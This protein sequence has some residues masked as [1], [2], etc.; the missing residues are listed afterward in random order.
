MGRTLRDQDLIWVVPCTGGIDFPIDTPAMPMVVTILEQEY[1]VQVQYHKFLNITYV[2]LDA[3]IFRQQTKSDPYPARMDDLDSAIYYSAWNQC[4][5]EVMR[6]FHVDLYHINDYH[7][8]V[9]PLYLL[10]ERT[11]P[12]CLSLHNAEFQGLWPCRTLKERQEIGEVF[13]LPQSVVQKYVQFGEVFNLLHAGASILR[14][15]QNGFGAVGVSTKYGKRSYIR[16]PIFWGLKRVGAL[17]NPDPTDMEDWDKSFNNSKLTVVDQEFEAR[18]PSQKRQAQEW[19]GL[20]QRADAD[21][22]VFVGRWSMQKGIDLIADVFP[23]VLERYA[24]VQLLCI[25]PVIDLYGK[26]AALKLQKMMVKYPGRVFSKPEFTALPPFVFTG[27]EFA[28]IPSRDEPFGLVAVEFGR[29][30]ALGVGARVGG[31]GQ[32]PGWWY[33]IESMTTKHLVYQ[34][35]DAIHQALKS[36][37]D[38]R[39]TMRARSAKTRFPVQQWKADLEIL[40]SGSI[41]AHNKRLQSK[42]MTST[43]WKSS[44]RSASKSQLE[45]GGQP[46]TSSLGG[47]STPSV[48]RSPQSSVTATREST[49]SQDTDEYDMGTR[50]SP[51]RYFR[52]CYLHSAL[53]SCDTSQNTSP[54]G[55]IERQSS[56][57]TFRSTPQ[58]GRISASYKQNRSIRVATSRTSSAEVIRSDHERMSF[59]SADQRFLRPVRNTIAVRNSL[60]T[61]PNP[62]VPLESQPE[63]SSSRVASAPA[64]MCSPVDIA[65]YKSTVTIPSS[66][67][68]KQP[69]PNL[70]DP[71]RSTRSSLS[72]ESN[73]E[74]GTTSPRREF[75][76]FNQRRLFGLVHCSNR[77][78]SVFSGSTRLE[79]TR[80]QQHERNLSLEEV[81][82]CKKVKEQQDLVPFFTDPTGQYYR[83]F[84]SKLEKLSAKTS[85]GSL[86]V[87]E[88]L[89]ES[90]RDWFNRLHKAR[91]TPASS[92]TTTPAESVRDS[93]QDSDLADDN[94]D[95]FLLPDAYEPPKG[96][97]RLL[98]S[99]IHRHGWP[100][101]TLLLALGQILSANSYQVTLL[102]GQIGQPASKLYI[103]ACIYLVSSL[104]CWIAFRW[105]KALYILCLPWLFY[106]LAF[107]F[108]G[109]SP[110]GQTVS[111]RGWIQDTAVGLYAVASAAG[112]F[113]FAQ[114][115]GSQGPQPVKTW[116]FRACAVQGTQQIYVIAL[117]YWG[118]RI[119][120][121]QNAGIT[122]TIMDWRTTAITMPIAVLLWAIGLVL[123][124]GLPDFYRQAPGAIPSFYGSTFR[125]KIIVWFFITVA[126][127][128]YFLSAPYGRNWAYLWSSK[129]APA[130]AIGVLITVFFVL[131][132]AAALIFFS[133]QSVTHSWI[134]PIFSI[135][136]GSPRWCQMLWSTSNVGT[137][138]PWAGGPIASALLGRSLWLWLGVL[139]ALQSVGFGMILLQTLTRF[140]LTF[141][142]VAAQVIGS[143][144]T[145]LARATANNKIGPGDVFP[146]FSVN[147]NGL[148]KGWFWAALGAQLLICAGFFKFFRKE[149]L[150]KP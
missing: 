75:D 26:F 148:T 57:S 124:L 30:G 135:G 72:R 6:R 115:F 142:L 56:E 103:V 93:V 149:Q 112:S 129:H 61:M 100:V 68:L 139:D 63:D 31:L 119:S 133:Y 36:N 118:S 10:P 104:I 25:G 111:A 66:L 54:T 70:S 55:P 138:I 13:N 62:F 1:S 9:A 132:W 41:R 96:L 71:V 27:A 69:K 44:L 116:G 65:N 98:N 113:F 21:L 43:S 146:D 87:E 86:C 28:L 125:R 137:Y 109:I 16:Y 50:S 150:S 81:H 52:L 114:N 97:K 91:M 106:G 20:E 60:A 5:A 120:V 102:T 8:T 110:Y 64:Q 147:F 95:Q 101:Y 18:R 35:K 105:F 7:G 108:L 47:W 22:F 122:S 14:I 3:P 48:S 141:A 145:I 123:F 131:I 53:S 140:H 134:L 107:F 84:E 127:Q 99:K 144:F 90:E 76:S 24:H 67:V 136:L 32:V 40:Q 143:I 89:M 12:C 2:L 19:A 45:A 23:E 83:A 17:P 37:V 117:W 15:H 80:S 92:R 38:L 121:H 77:S 130:W 73:H 58:S 39:A 85:E 128:T 126:L 78:E 42:S 29:K 34:F 33:T 74:Q 51:S 11:I 49:P 94:L 46:D 4:I 88:Y 82:R 59:N 79:D